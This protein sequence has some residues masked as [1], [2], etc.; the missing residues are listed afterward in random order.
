MLLACPSL[1][2][3]AVMSGDGSLAPWTAAALPEPFTIQGAAAGG[4]HPGGTTVVATA[5]AL[6][7]STHPL[8]GSG[9]VVPGTATGTPDGS[10]GR[11]T[12]GTVAP[13]GA[14]PVE[15]V[16]N[17]VAVPPDA[18]RESEAVPNVPGDEPEGAVAPVLQPV[19]EL[20]APPATGVT[21]AIEPALS[22][23]NPPLLA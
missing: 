18:P 3:N 23:L 1:V 11:G 12:D 14:V 4:P 15:P 19:T 8:T 2:A 9:L 13:S 5:T 22:M 16:E 10:P 21:E 7:A 20:L 6:T 17:P